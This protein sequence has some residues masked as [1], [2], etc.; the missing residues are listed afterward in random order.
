MRGLT[1]QVISDNHGTV[2]EWSSVRQM[3]RAVVKE[4][5]V[6]SATVTAFIRET[7]PVYLLV[8]E[9]DHRAGV[10]SQLRIRLAALS[11]RRPLSEAEL[12]ASG[13][14]AAE[15]AAQNIP[16]DALIAAHQAGDQEIW[17]LVIERGSAGL[18]PLMPEIGHMMF[19]ATSAATEVM[20]R[21]HS[22]VARDIDG[23]RITLAHQFLELLDDPAERAEATLAGTRLGFDAHGEFVGLAWLPAEEAHV[24][25][26]EAAASLGSESIDIVVR[27]VGEGRFEMIAQA[28]DP[29]ILVARV[30]ERL[31]GGRV[32]IG[33]ARS[34]LAGAVMS[35]ADARIALAATSARRR[36][37]RFADA[38]PEALALSESDR[39]SMMTQHAADVATAEP[40]LA[41][42]VLAF[43]A[44]DLSI[45][46]TAREVHLHANSVTYRLHR[47]AQLTGMNPRTFEGLVRS[48]IACRQ[49]EGSVGPEVP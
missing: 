41:E 37:V 30:T 26:Y 9:V 19:A 33:L 49:A 46:S 24:V 43:A 3:C 8:P 12:A 42:T 6:I 35:L 45:A 11:Q 25:P 28:G 17:R 36:L 40:H 1:A 32:G 22:R 5:P 14:L 29:Q 18:A 4:L 23:G 44:A 27:A 7:V 21:A 39:I 47:W 13:E 16:I 2:P 48:V 31:V 38:W 20:A 34:G 15:R 10:E